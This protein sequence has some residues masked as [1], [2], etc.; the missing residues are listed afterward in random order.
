MLEK[1]LLH[2]ERVT[3]RPITADDAAAM[4]AALDDTESMRL[5]GTQESFTRAQVADFCA[6]VAVADDRADY[7]IT[8][9]GDPTYIGEAV[10]NGIDWC[11]RSAN[12]RI[13]L[14]SA[15][16]FGQGYGTEATRLIVAYGFEQLRLHRIAL[17]VY[18]FNSRARHV[19]EKIGF[20]EEGVR[21]DALYWDGQFHDAVMM[22]M[23]EQEY[24]RAHGLPPAG[25]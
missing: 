3:L 5:T 19:Y 25:D 24:R 7:A 17:E 18:A 9:K 15:V 14:A 8:L 23:L 4:F 12:F 21:R 2:G 22:S 16:F 1:P 10:L 20:R 6:R 13:A 11:N